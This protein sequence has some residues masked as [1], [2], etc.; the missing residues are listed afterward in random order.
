MSEWRNGRLD[1]SGLTTSTPQEK[2]EPSLGELV[3]AA[4]R[5]ASI[6]IRSEIELAKRELKVEARNAAVGGGMFGGAAVF[7]L[8]ALIMLSFAAAFGLDTVLPTWAAFLIVGGSYLLFA[9][10]MALIGVGAIKK[11]GPPK[12]TLRTAKETVRVL[13]TRGKA[14]KGNKA[15]APARGA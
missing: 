5:D 8:F 11:V 4:S 14:G 12:R 1:G 15:A 7:G 2:A 13:K 3:A 6:L 10:V 9:V